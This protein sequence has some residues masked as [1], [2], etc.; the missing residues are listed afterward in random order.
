MLK[1]VIYKEECQ[2][3]FHYALF[4]NSNG[5]SLIDDFNFINET[6]SYFGK[7][8]EDIIYPTNENINRFNEILNVYQKKIDCFGKQANTDFY[9]Q[10]VYEKYRYK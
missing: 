5:I 6:V 10:D 1:S 8:F 4:A 3:Y 7:S 2:I 9:S